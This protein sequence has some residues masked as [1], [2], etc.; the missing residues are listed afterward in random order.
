MW[1]FGCILAE[2]FSG[3]PLF[4]GANENDQIACIIEILGAPSKRF[5]DKCRRSQNFFRSKGSPR[6]CA[7]STDPI[8]QVYLQGGVLP[9]GNFRGPPKSKNLSD[10]LEGCDDKLFIDFLRGCLELDPSI[11]LTPQSALHH[12]W[13]RTGNPQAGD[14]N[15][16]QCTPTVSQTASQQTL[17]GSRRTKTHFFGG[18]SSHSALKATCSE[19]KAKPFSKL[20]LANKS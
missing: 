15:H 16:L 5:L 14:N 12:A 1:S 19:I 17:P 11:R 9:G 18:S 8:G 2:M 4:P 3:Q 6:Y 10:V 13:M 7:I 20:K